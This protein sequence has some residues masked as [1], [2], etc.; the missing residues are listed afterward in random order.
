MGT[1]RG[2][3]LLT[4]RENSPFSD[5]VEDVEATSDNSIAEICR[6]LSVSKATLYRAIGKGEAKRLLAATRPGRGDSP[7]TGHG[8]DRAGMTE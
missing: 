7:A 8:H 1:R 6:T 4:G 5:S 3:P 2:R